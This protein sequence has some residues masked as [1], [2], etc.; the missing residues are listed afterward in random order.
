MDT[1]TEVT[2]VSTS[3]VDANLFKIPDGY[4]QVEPKNVQ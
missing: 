1:S 3:T 2:S 4:K